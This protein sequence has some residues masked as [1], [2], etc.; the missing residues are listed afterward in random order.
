MAESDDGSE[1][2]TFLST[3]DSEELLKQE[4][5]FSGRLDIQTQVNTEKPS[6]L[7]NLI[8]HYGRDMSVV[9]ATIDRVSSMT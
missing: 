8:L 7:N 6:F 4:R 2:N 5:L 1:E 3:V 9:S